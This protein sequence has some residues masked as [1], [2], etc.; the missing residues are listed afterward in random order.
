M[1]EFLNGT[2]PKTVKSDVC[3][4]GAGP[5]G[6]M[7]ALTLAESGISSILLEGGGPEPGGISDLELYKGK[8]T[9]I[10]YPLMASRL[11][12]LGGT[13]ATWGGWS[14]PLEPE[15][16]GSRQNAI[17]PSWPIS[18][19]DLLPHY[20]NALRWCEIE[21]DDF[22]ASSS[23][24]DASSQLLFGE[25]MAFTQDLLR[26]SPPTRFGTR[27]RH[28]IEESPH[29][30][31]FCHAN[32]VSLQHQGDRIVSATARNLDGN[33]LEVRADHFVL[34]MGGLEIPRFLLH[35]ADDS[36]VA[37]GNGSGLLGQC[38]MDQFGFSPGHMIAAEGLKLYRHRSGDA[39]IQPMLT[40]S[41]AFQVDN[42]LPS[43]CMMA[44]PDS[45]SRNFPGGYFDN[46]GMLDDSVGE[47]G[48][49]RLQMMCEPGIHRES[50]VSLGDDRDA[51][52]MQRIRLNWY[53]SDDDY[54]GA[55]RFVK[56][57]GREL[58]ATG[59]GRLQQT[60]H[61]DTE[62][63][64]KLSVTWHHNGTTRMSDNPKYGVVNPDCGVYGTSNLNIAS[65]S[66]FPR[67]GYSNPTLAILALTDRLAVSLVQQG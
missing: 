30:R 63:R 20:A 13:S 9:G 53:L 55:E 42:D 60:E 8:S 26:F 47:P 16:F 23:V 46:P 40:A 2:T 65:S 52:G 48:R 39:D 64:K 19:D 33:S 5:A 17:L 29:V 6:I 36:G 61:F 7:L 21:N 28:D 38:F 35:T 12:Y 25:G 59:L 3:I 54:Q 67:S 27:Y 50:A 22:N 37:F 1:L 62:S 56:H 44:T 41:S 66:V 49:Y 14:K 45:E 10:R 32:L 43:V 57:L 51:L 31:C 11:R 34:A 15:A 18:Y 58:G 24:E 4:A